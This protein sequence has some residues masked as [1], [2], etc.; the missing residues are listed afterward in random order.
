MFQVVVP[1]L[2]PHTYLYCLGQVWVMHRRLRL[3]L[4]YKLTYNIEPNVTLMSG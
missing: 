2:H 4:T 1:L 3:E